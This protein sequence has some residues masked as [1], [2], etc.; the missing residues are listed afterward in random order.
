MCDE[1]YEEGSERA[2]HHGHVLPQSGPLRQRWL[3][4]FLPWDQF[5]DQDSEAQAWGHRDALS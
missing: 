3:A 5:H 4:S 2:L 1:I